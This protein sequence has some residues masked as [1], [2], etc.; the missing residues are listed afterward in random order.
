MY[1][2]I[3]VGARASGSSTA[4]LAANAGLKVLLID[5]HKFPSDTISTN[6]IHQPG[7][8]QL[9]R[10]GLLNKIIAAGTPPITST[11][12][13]IKDFA[14]HGSISKNFDQLEA[15]APRRYILDNILLEAAK[16]A[17]VD[18]REN[19]TL[20]GLEWKNGRC[21]GIKARHK[22]KHISTEQAHLIIGADGMRSSTAN[23]VGARMTHYDML[24]TCVYYSFWEQLKPE[25]ELY[26][27]SDCWV[28]AI[29][30]NNNTLIATYFPQ[31]AFNAVRK[32][33]MKNHLNAIKL[34]APLLYEK[35]QSAK[36][37][38]GLWGTGDQQNFFRQAAGPGW[39]LV[40]DAGHHKDSITARG[41]TDSLIQAEL[42][43]SHIKHTIH[44]QKKLDTSLYDYTK[45]RD[46]LMMPGYRAA[47]S[48]ANLNTQPQRIDILR[49]VA[50][51]PQAKSLYF[52]V[53]AGIRPYTELDALLKTKLESTTY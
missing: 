11:R 27:S 47:L 4:W 34:A 24:L 8:A 31:S 53:I 45:D 23:L 15:Y 46:R 26:E 2:V 42:L 38:E 19:C 41:I 33:A 13:Q 50:Q 12:L 10:W 1:D 43:V 17:N 51:T 9:K 40:G 14:I 44:D 3:I 49:L 16:E 36:L 25:Y 6:Y 28:G 52:D 39:A 20:L 37:V 7:C 29:P 5:R 32:N 18:V 22:N 30:T 48:V 35:T 21:C